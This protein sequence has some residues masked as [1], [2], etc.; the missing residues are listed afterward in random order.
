MAGFRD[1][2][3]FKRVFEQVFQLM[4]DHPEVGRRLRD[5]QAPHKF[6]ITDL[7]LEFHVVA[8]PADQ[9]A[10]GRFLEWYWGPAKE[11]P[12]IT[13]TMASDVANRY[14]Q[15]KESV[16]MAVLSGR[17]K[18]AGPMPKIMELAPVTTP[19]NAVYRAW[20]SANGYDHLVA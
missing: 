3:E 12:M 7:G 2:A 15:G 5:A 19:V 17:V 13:L 8:A 18:I 20:L 9:E 1:A 14:F 10:A 11:P 6:D 4:N 16:M